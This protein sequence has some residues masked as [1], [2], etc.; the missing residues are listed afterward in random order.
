MHHEKTIVL[1]EI[2]A[3]VPQGVLVLTGARK[4]EYIRPLAIVHD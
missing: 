3:E 4:N 1:Q 2:R